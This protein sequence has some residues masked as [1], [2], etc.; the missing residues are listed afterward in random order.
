VLG[1]ALVVTERGAGCCQDPAQTVRY[2]NDATRPDLALL[3]GA[4]DAAL[5]ARIG[6]CARPWSGAARALFVYTNNTRAA[7]VSW[8]T[9]FVPIGRKRCWWCRAREAGARR[10]YLSRQGW[11]E[12][13]SRV[14]EVVHTPHRLGPRA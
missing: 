8:L 1:D 2:E 4:A 3:G 5:A 9:G 7:G 13:T 14:A 12:R 10:T 11:I 6:G